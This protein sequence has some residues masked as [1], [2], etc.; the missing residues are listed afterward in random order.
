MDM[1]YHYITDFI[2]EFE[3]SAMA[4][5]IADVSENMLFEK[6]REDGVRELDTLGVP[7]HDTYFIQNKRLNY[8]NHHRDYKDEGWKVVRLLYDLRVR[9]FY[10]VV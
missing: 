1:K 8:F 3:E 2:E 10:Y 5:N 7:L 6:L 9:M 4:F